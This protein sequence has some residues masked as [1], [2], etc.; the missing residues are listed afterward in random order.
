MGFACREDRGVIVAV[1]E[2]PLEVELS[3]ADRFRDDLL[4][5]LGDARLAVLDASAIEFFDS[6]GMG[7]LLAVQRNLEKRGGRLALAGLSRP[8][9]EVFRMIGFDMVFPIHPDVAAAVA[10]LGGDR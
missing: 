8:I 4:A 5:T 6:A 7:A 1:A 9:Q 3:N 2:G 10:D